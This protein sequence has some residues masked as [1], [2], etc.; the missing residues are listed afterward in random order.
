[1]RKNN[2]ILLSRRSAVAG[3]TGLALSPL[4]PRIARAAWT[5]TQ[6][7]TVVVHWGA[8]GGTD[9]VFRGLTEIVNSEGLSPQPWVVTNRT[10][11][12]GLNGFKYLLDQEGDAHTIGAV[13][14]AI[15]SALHAKKGDMDWRK[16]MPVSNL[17]VDPQFLVV[18]H[19]TPYK[20]LEDFVSA[21]KAKPGTIT[22]AGAQFGQEDHLTNLVMEKGTGIKTKFIP[23]EG[24]V[25]V[26]QNLAGGHVNAGWLNPSEV[27]GSLA[28]QG[29]TLVVLAVAMKDRLP[30]YP[31]VPTFVEK[32]HD[33]IFDMFFRGVLAPP[34]VN[35]D[36]IAFYSDVIGKATSS[37]KWKA[38]C[39]KTMV[40]SNYM[41][42]K[43]YDA[44]L[45]RWDKT[46]KDLMP[47]VNASKQ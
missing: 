10:G 46:I 30:A 26:K 33:V 29:G 16:A 1:M 13:T 34:K 39:E 42:A 27:V 14:P 24:G 44:A 11:G 19:K 2:R 40:V 45:D 3:L 9:I 21:A 35:P 18:Y 43:D 47:L 4:A 6:P 31:D 7:V 32:G 12:A 22:V 8:G 41:P 17:I 38:F 36:A 28:S 23:V 5:P 25:Q 15:P 20:T 37:P